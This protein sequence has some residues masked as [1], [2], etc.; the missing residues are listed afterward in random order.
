MSH[1]SAILAPEKKMCL[2]LNFV[3]M[4]FKTSKP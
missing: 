2:I 3:D 1:Y 4:T